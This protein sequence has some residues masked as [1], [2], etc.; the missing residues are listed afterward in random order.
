MVTND[1]ELLLTKCDSLYNA[2]EHEL[3]QVRSE[4]ANFQDPQNGWNVFHYSAHNLS[5][6]ITENLVKL[7]AGRVYII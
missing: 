2:S 3:N 1:Y 7:L 4:V 6:S 5:D